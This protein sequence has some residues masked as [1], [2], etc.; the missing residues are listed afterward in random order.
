MKSS[1]GASWCFLFSLL[2]MGLAGYLTYLHIGLMRGEL[3]GGSACSSGVFNCHAVTSGSWG[4]VLGMPLALWGMLGYITVFALSILAWQ[5]PEWAEHAMALIAGL[6][7]CF[8]LI[9]LALLVVMVSVIRLYCLFCLLTY[10]V[11]V[12]LL[13][14]AWRAAPPPRSAIMGRIGRALA[15]LL[16]SARRPLPACVWGMLC[17][18]FVGVIGVH[19]ATTFVSRGSIGS[20]RRSIQEFLARQPRVTVAGEGDPALG[21]A[22]APVQIIEFSDFLCPACQRAAKINAV[23]LANHRQDVRFTFKHYPLD[24]SCNDRVSRMVHPG[25]CRVAAASE[26][27]HQQGKFWALHD[28]VFEKGHDYQVSQLEADAQRL[29]LDLPRFRACLESGEGLEAV[30]R[31]IAQGAQVGVTSTPTYVI[32]GVPVAGGFNP[33]GLEDFIAAV[34]GQGT[35]P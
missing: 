18:G 15:A 30:K 17:L 2:G 26:C 1:R 19:A 4:A 29:G 3:L 13:G 16:P 24:M 33:S 5:S 12:A 10:A 22:N 32:N 9:D 25:A 8:V 14:I 7:L 11:N 31:D 35:S 27:A 34:Q 20:T 23:I 28:L 6:A 21:P